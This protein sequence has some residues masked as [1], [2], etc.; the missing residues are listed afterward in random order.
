[1]CMGVWWLCGALF[2]STCT[3]VCYKCHW[4]FWSIFF[5]G[6][7]NQQ[8]EWPKVLFTDSNETDKSS[9]RF[10]FA[11]PH[12]PKA[13]LSYFARINCSRVYG[14]IYYIEFRN[15]AEVLW[16]KWREVAF[17]WQS[18]VALGFQSARWEMRT[19]EKHK[20]HTLARAYLWS[21]SSQQP[22]LQ[23]QGKQKFSK[24]GRGFRISITHNPN[25]T[26]HFHFVHDYSL[27]K[28]RHS[29]HTHTPTEICPKMTQN[30][31]IDEIKSSSSSKRK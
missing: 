3:N 1:M 16:T 27:S 19:H 14:E 26:V 24:C 25:Q 13:F 10:W 28:V 2:K 31:T 6:H 20:R 11:L 4:Q 15:V 18:L 30:T 12:D 5:G 7:V 17:N 22:L 23:H 9:R 8:G 21:A 29:K